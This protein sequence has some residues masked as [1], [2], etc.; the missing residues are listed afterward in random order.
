MF[1]I[2]SAEILQHS[3]KINKIILSQI[4]KFGP[5]LFLLRSLLSILEKIFKLIFVIPYS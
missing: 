5:G 1:F 4:T 2:N 3:K